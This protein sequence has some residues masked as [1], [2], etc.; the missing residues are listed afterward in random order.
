MTTA[1]HDSFIF[2][3]FRLDV[4]E[5]VLLRRGKP[6]YLPPKAFATLLLLVQ[7]SGRVVEKDELVRVVWPDAYVEEANV[8]QNIFKLRK[9]LGKNRMGEPYI[10]TVPRRG[11]RF[12]GLVRTLKNS[13]ADY[14]VRVASEAF[15]EPQVSGTGQT[16][17][18]IAVLPLTNASTDEHTEYLSDGITESIINSLS[19]ISEL[20]VMARSSVSSYKGREVDPKQVGRELD[21]ETVLIGKV[22]QLSDHVVI[23]VELVDTSTGWQLWGEQYNRR[24]ADILEL[25]EEISREV[26]EQLSLKLTGKRKAV[27]VSAMVV[28]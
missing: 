19:G 5:R 6:V 13:S 20:R 24:P 27:F 1:K 25:Q 28:T 3:P 10:E 8:A 9:A 12:L 21:V 18:S 16:I 15:P 14:E 17:K 22:L 26:S 11:Y 2:G 4:N 23:R 7:K